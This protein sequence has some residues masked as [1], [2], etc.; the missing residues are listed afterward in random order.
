MAKRIPRD[1]EIK[2]TYQ[3]WAVEFTGE[4]NQLHIMECDDA[5]GVTAEENAYITQKMFGGRV[6][7]ADVYYTGWKYATDGPPGTVDTLMADENDFSIHL[8]GD[9]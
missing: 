9:L 4:D 3:A 5:N 1:V 2:D 6:I 8:D 7:Y